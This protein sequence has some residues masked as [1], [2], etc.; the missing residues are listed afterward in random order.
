[1]AGASPDHRSAS[2]PQAGQKKAEAHLLQLC[3][4]ETFFAPC[5][6]VQRLHDLEGQLAAAEA[7]AAS[8]SCEL[9]EARGEL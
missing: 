3:A 2:E 5:G 4:S 7:A 8:Q 1:M 9:Q 6:L